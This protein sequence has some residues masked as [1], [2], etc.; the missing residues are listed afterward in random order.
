MY[1]K[2]QFIIT[3]LELWKYKAGLLALSIEPLDDVGPVVAGKG[4]YQKINHSHSMYQVSAL[5]Y[6]ESLHHRE[7]TIIALITKIASFF[8]TQNIRRSYSKKPNRG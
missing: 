8:S 1:A 4:K 5:V 2:C 3:Y 6:T 7:Q